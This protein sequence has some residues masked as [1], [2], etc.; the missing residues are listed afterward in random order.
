MRSWL[1][2]CGA[3][4][5]MM[6]AAGS[7]AAAAVPT[8]PASANQ[9]AREAWVSEHVVLGQGV[10]SVVNEATAQI[11]DPY[12]F[13][14][15]ADGHLIGW[16]RAEY[17]RPVRDDGRTYRSSRNKVEIDC[18]TSALR[19]LGNESYP[20]NNLGG[21]PQPSA[22]Q[23]EWTDALA[24]GTAGGDEVRQ[25]CSYLPLVGSS[26]W[27][28]AMPPPPAAAGAA[29][30]QAWRERY[31][32][33]GEDVFLMNEGDIAT[34][35]SPNG[36]EKA[37]NGTVRARLRQ[38]LTAPMVLGATGVRST[39][40]YIE[41]DCEGMRY[42]Y[43]DLVVFPG[44]NTL[45]PPNSD[46]TD[47]GAENWRPAKAG[48]GK[49]QM[50]RGLCKLAQAPQTP[51]SEALKQPAPPAPTSSAEADIIE[52]Y[53]QRLNTGGMIS[54]FYADD[55]VEFFDPSQ[56]R[57][58]RDGSVAAVLRREYFTPMD[59]NG[60]EFRSE[61]VL[62][63]YDCRG[64]RMRLLGSTLF[65]EAN[66]EGEQK[67][68][69]DVPW[70]RLEADDTGIQLICGHRV[71]LT[72]EVDTEKAMIPSLWGPAARQVSAWL[73]DYVDPR[74]DV[75]VDYTDKGVG[76]YSSELGE[77]T[78]QGHLRVWLRY[79][80]F[81][82]DLVDGKVVRSTRTLT[83]F[84]CDQSRTRV[85]AFED[86]PGSNLQGPKSEHSFS[87]AEWSFAAP[88][89]LQSSFLNTLCSLKDEADEAAEDAV[90]RPRLRGPNGRLPL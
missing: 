11:F 76:F 1:G 17:F 90:S 19:V 82:P 71:L 10:L 61:L 64:R 84:D 38:E 85:L 52:W 41:L 75:L 26:D 69:D 33:A 9:E 79:E 45:G 66:L 39:R 49:A 24:E 63:E 46:F 30:L 67:P 27:A 8:L 53:N 4:L 37:Q 5:A 25:A 23:G 57:L 15:T 12:D 34:F 70:T 32:E 55:S 80:R 87:D 77:R 40:S 60:F 2:V 13:Q 72:G 43:L 21:A 42:Q 78:R 68:G 35:Y 22:V 16:F 50:V 83:E 31:I 59:Y 73:L 86:Y 47:D 36:F 6:T 74:D 54:T 3:A 28:R 18:A 29:G 62:G 65:S 44:S 89:S 58:A 88:K 20:L 14:K 7:P 81:E 51:P 48:E 56:I